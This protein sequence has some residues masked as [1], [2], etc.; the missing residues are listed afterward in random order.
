MAQRYTFTSRHTTWSHEG[1]AS[2]K[3]RVT[4]RDSAFGNT[5]T[6]DLTAAEL[7]QLT[8]HCLRALAFT[9]ESRR[10]G[11]HLSTWNVAVDKRVEPIMKL[12]NALL[13]KTK[14]KAA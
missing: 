4:I 8:R 11:Q 10:K 7:R 13:P 1:G 9:K 6:Y 12:V 3:G 5:A 2:P 14:S